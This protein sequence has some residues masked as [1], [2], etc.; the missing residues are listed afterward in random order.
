MFAT[1]LFLILFI[2]PNFAYFNQLKWIP[3]VDEF[4]NMQNMLKQ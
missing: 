4:I 3:K 2:K 1:D